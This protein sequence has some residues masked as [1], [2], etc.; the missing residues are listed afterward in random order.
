MLLGA[1]QSYEQFQSEL[2]KFQSDD[3]RVADL[4]ARPRNS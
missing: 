2:Q 4:R 1:A 3:P